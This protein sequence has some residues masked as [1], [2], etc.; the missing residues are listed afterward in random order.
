MVHQYMPG[1]LGEGCLSTRI[2]WANLGQQHVCAPLP[3]NIDQRFD[4]LACSRAVRLVIK[5]SL[6]VALQ[7]YFHRHSS[8]SSS[9][10]GT[11]TG[12]ACACD[13]GRANIAAAM[14]GL[15]SADMV[16]TQHNILNKHSVLLGPVKV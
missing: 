14:T 6:K 1:P 15:H 11:I 3:A 5:E 16:P 9:H 8:S 4:K 12:R 2:S 7:V 13:V 10:P